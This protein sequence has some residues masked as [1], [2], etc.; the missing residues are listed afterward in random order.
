MSESN[1]QIDQATREMLADLKE[2]V[3]RLE[4]PILLIGARARVLIF[5]SQYSE[6]RKTTDWDLAIKMDD[7]SRY[8]SLISEM[9]Q[10]ETARFETTRVQH[11]FIHRSTRIEVD[12]VPFGTIS[13]EQQEITWSD[14]N[15]MSVLGLQEA[16]LTAHVEKIDG[17]EIRVLSI[18]A[19]VGLK[20]LAWH[21][22]QE[23]KDLLDIAHILGNYTDEQRI[24]AALSS[25]I[26]QGQL[27]YENASC[28]L[29]GQDIKTIFQNATLSKICEYLS[30]LIEQQNRYFP[31]LISK[32]LPNDVWDEEFD[33]IVDQFNA[34]RYGIS[35]NK[36]SPGRHD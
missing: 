1:A 24:E 6:G 23:T 5:D 25:E 22:R 10:I 21:E 30:Q 34:L 33:I 8:Q 12:I 26:E 17:I 14:G 7:W 15:Q 18:P 32:D 3:D 16:F 4:L 29:I 27:N 2:I 28:A 20:I 19:I 31:R 35:A 13:D 9:T 36:E 11:K